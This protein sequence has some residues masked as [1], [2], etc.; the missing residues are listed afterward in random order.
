MKHTSKNMRAIALVLVGFLM[1]N[2]ADAF[3]NGVVDMYHFGTISFYTALSQII[4]IF[5][6]SKPL[7]GLKSIVKTTKLKILIIKGIVSLIGSV[8]FIISIRYIVLTQAYTLILT[9]PFWV[10]LISIVFLQK[11][12]GWHRW[13][14]I[15]IG[16]SG[17]LI[18]LQPW[19]DSIHIAAFG[20][21]ICGICA[22]T[23]MILSRIIGEK[24]P[25]INLVFYV[26]C[27][28]S[29]A[30]AIINTLWLGWE[31]VKPEHIGFFISAGALFI[32]GNILFF[33]GFTTGDTDLL[34]PLHYSQIIWGAL[35]G[36]FFFSEVP[37]K[38]TFIG[39]GIMILSGIYL[40]YRERKEST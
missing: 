6:I 15:I 3:I 17:V 2:I 16:F 27:V 4:F 22:A 37:E 11:R 36:Y 19:S 20:A 24:E 29:I 26:V 28:I 23:N 39:A 31:T 12:I 13:L 32:T 18:V 25:L 14:T 7:G 1:F 35:I 38:W 9:S 8:G 40:I 21:L 10:A 33:K 5:I 34:A 30:F